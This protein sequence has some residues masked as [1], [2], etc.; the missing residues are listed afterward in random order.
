MIKVEGRGKIITFTFLENKTNLSVED[1]GAIFDLFY[2][3]LYKKERHNS[4]KRADLILKSDDSSCFHINI[5]NLLLFSKKHDFI[6]HF[7][8]N[9]IGPKRY[10]NSSHLPNDSSYAN[11]GTILVVSASLEFTLKISKEA[12][13]IHS[14]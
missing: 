12:S 13:Y 6:A 3:H 1:L 10:L 5:K 8:R 11:S 14:P 4:L 2:E 9:I 7:Y